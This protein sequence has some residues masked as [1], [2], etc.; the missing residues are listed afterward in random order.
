MSGPVE[1][2]DFLLQQETRDAS[3][4]FGGVPAPRSGETS[5]VTDEQVR[6]AQLAVARSSR[7]V[8]DC[9]ELLDMLGLVPGDDGV[10]PAQR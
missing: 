9:R 8:E 5:R 10:P 6:R 2:R 7:D 3:L 4:G 1:V